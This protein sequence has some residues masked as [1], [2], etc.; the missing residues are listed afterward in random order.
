[1]KNKLEAFIKE[2]KKSFDEQGPSEELWSKIA[3]NLDEDKKPRSVKRFSWMSIAAILVLS[4]G[5]YFVG[6]YK[7]N[8]GEVRIADVSSDYGKKEARF[9]SLIEAKKDSLNTLSDNNPELYQSFTADIAKLDA[10]YEQLKKE[11]QTSPNRSAVVKAMMKNLEIRSNILSQ[12]L[13]II[14]QVNQIKKD[15]LI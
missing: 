5:I 8:N 3:Q 9:T 12:Q 13:N 6:R 10:E 1:M 15:N 7:S 4:M 11:L 2:N 14:N